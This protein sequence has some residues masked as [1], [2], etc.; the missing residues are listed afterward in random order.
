[1]GKKDVVTKD[2]MDHAEIFADAFNYFLFGGR[3]VIDPSKLHTMDTTEIGMP[4]G[5]GN[6]E[7]PV[8]KFRDDFKYLSAMEDETA[9][10]LLLGIENQSEIHYAMAVKNMVYD[11]LQYASQVEKAAISHR[12]ARKEKR[13]SDAETGKIKQNGKVPNTAE[14]LSGF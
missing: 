4:Y 11:A 2:Y 14:Y 3:E 12:K 5:D 7:T 8:Q 6:T 9:A 10:Y 1:M 13:I